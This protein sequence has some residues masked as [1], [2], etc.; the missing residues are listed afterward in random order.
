[1]TIEKL[2]IFIWCNW[3]E[4][5]EELKKKIKEKKNFYA[6]KVT[7]FCQSKLIMARA[8]EIFDSSTPKKGARVCVNYLGLWI[9][10]FGLELSRF[11]GSSEKIILWY[12]INKI[13][14]HL[15]YR[16]YFQTLQTHLHPLMNNKNLSVKWGRMLES[17]V[18]RHQTQLP[19][20]FSEIKND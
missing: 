14:K 4:K 9:S 18:I 8:K 17:P 12:V 13:W 10:L 5:L 2:S 7:K 3:N 20:E 19:T 15:N 1:M 16:I 11:E 6:W